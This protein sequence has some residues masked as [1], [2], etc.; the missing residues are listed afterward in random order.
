MSRNDERVKWILWGVFFWMF[1]S[2][3]V[4]V[5]V[6]CR[7]KRFEWDFLMLFKIFLD[8]FLSPREHTFQDV[9]LILSSGDFELEIFS[10]IIWVACG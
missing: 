1:F 6:S 4:E 7:R 2:V 10:S 3:S 5:L 9:S 8:F